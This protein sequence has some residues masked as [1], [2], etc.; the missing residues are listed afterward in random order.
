MREQRVR[1][2]NVDKETY[3]LVQLIKTHREKLGMTQAEAARATKTSQSA[4]SEME[5]GVV[6]PRASTLLRAFTLLGLKM[7]VES[8][9]RVYLKVSMALVPTGD[10]RCTRQEIVDAALEEIQREFIDADGVSWM[11][12]DVRVIGEERA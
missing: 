5:A 9:D 11:I 12:R 10:S 7:R 1:G 2:V 8:D 6:E 3:E 4:W